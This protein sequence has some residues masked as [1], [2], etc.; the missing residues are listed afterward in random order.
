MERRLR[1]AGNSLRSQPFRGRPFRGDIRVLTH[2]RP[3]LGF[4]RVRAGH[5]LLLTVRH[6]ARR[7]L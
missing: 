2:V 7:P 5:V 4:Y 6:G 1:S 3:Y